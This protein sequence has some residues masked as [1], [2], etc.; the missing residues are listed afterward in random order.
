MPLLLGILITPL[1]L[2]AAGILALEGPKAF[3]LLYP[4]VEVVRSRALH[5]PAGLVGNASEWMMYLQ[6]PLYGLIIM[7]TWR[8]G[9]YLRAFIIGLV[10]HFSGLVGVVVLAW[11]G[12]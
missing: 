12:Q 5:L 10:L 6:F 3:A 4:W 7:L 8:A 11:L 2:R 1:A 9:R